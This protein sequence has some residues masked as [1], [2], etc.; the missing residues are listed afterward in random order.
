MLGEGGMS[1]VY[2]AVDLR[3]VEAGAAD[4]KI[5]ANTFLTQPLD[6]RRTRE[7]SKGAELIRRFCDCTH[8]ITAN[9]RARA[10]TR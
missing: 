8:A 6:Q 1:H 4:F 9:Y 7:R 5:K 2:K 10:P 3:K